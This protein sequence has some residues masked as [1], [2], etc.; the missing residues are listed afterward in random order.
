MANQLQM[1][2]PKRSAASVDRER[3][4]TEMANR[5]IDA[6]YA[7][8][9]GNLGEMAFVFSYALAS[10]VRSWPSKEGR[11][12]LAKAGLLLRTTL[13]ATYEIPIPPAVRHPEAR[14]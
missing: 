1:L 7:D 2:S 12:T 11:E 5:L 9:H 4:L 10:V 8:C 3:E 13:R 6:V 14:K